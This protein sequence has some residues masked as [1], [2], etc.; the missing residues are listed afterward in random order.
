[1]TVYEIESF[2]LLAFL[3]LAYSVSLMRIE[4]LRR[5]V[6]LDRVPDML[7]VWSLPLQSRCRPPCLPP[8]W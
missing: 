2:A 6:S 3:S 7:G 4:T 1:M 5:V 8:L